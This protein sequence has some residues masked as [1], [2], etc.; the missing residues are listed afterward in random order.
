MGVVGTTVF[1]AMFWRR[2]P[3]LEDWR[4]ALVAMGVQWAVVAMFTPFDYT[5]S[6]F[7]MFTFAGIVAAPRFVR[8]RPSVTSR[9]RAPLAFAPGA[10]PLAEDSSHG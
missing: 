9:I 4:I 7:F 1:A 3:E 5:F 10:R 6:M 2:P 8:P